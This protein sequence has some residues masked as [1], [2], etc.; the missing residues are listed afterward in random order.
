MVSR[1]WL[2][3]RGIFTQT[4]CFLFNAQTVLEGI[5]IVVSY[6]NDFV[7]IRA[8]TVLRVMMTMMSTAQVVETCQQQS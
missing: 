3:E 2:K 8:P 6:G 7:S 5:E 1:T 4:K